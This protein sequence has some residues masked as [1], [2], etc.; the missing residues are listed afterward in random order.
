MNKNIEI[1]IKFT[2]KMLKNKP[3]IN[4]IISIKLIKILKINVIFIAI[5]LEF[6][7]LINPAR[8]L[9]PSSGKHGSKLN[10][11]MTTFAMQNK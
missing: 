4:T 6:F 3:K 1:I 7:L 5:F 8:T 10:K 2:L 11:N 9:P